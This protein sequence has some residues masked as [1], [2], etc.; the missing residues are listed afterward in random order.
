MMDTDVEYYIRCASLPGPRVLLTYD[1]MQAERGARRS[2]WDDISHGSEDWSSASSTPTPPTEAGSIHELLSPERVPDT[3]AVITPNPIV[4]R[5]LP[6]SA[7]SEVHHHPGPMGTWNADTTTKWLREL[8]KPILPDVVCETLES[9]NTDGFELME[10]IHGKD[11]EELF[12]DIGLESRLARRQFLTTAK[13]AAATA[14]NSPGQMSTRTVQS[15]SP[16]PS[17]PFSPSCPSTSST[18]DKQATLVGEKA[19]VMP[20]IPKPTSQRTLCTADKFKVFHEN[21]EMWA[22]ANGNHMY[23]LAMYIFS[24]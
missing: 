21:C 8:K 6:T 18:P 11:A 1:M 14:A 2:L 15:P 22:Q 10:M 9:Y 5:E 20:T 17:T 12:Q 24:E 23:I 19:I 7:A 4:Q 16:T 13:K 3:T